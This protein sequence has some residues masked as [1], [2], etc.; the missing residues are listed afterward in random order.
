MIGLIEEQLEEEILF[1]PVGAVE[2]LFAGATCVPASVAKSL[3]DLFA[4]DGQFKGRETVESDDTQEP[5]T[6]SMR[7]LGGEKPAPWTG[8]LL[9]KGKVTFRNIK[10][11]P[12]GDK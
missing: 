3:M 9:K 1:L 8:I 5:R 2:G 6:I 7:Y 10:I 4:R 11:R 12:L